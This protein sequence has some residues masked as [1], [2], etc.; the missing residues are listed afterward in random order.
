MPVPMVAAGAG[1]LSFSPNV[2]MESA[3]EQTAPPTMSVN[4]VTASPA[5]LGGDRSSR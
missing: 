4:I 5:L 1:W 2:Q 3:R